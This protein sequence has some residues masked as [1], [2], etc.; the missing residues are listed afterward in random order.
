MSAEILRKAASL[1]RERARA[2]LAEDCRDL[3]MA[4]PDIDADNH[5]W[6]ICEQR[7]PDVDWDTTVANLPYDYDGTVAQH[8]A[9]W[10]PA[11]ALA[12]ADWL[13]AYA[14]R[15]DVLGHGIG[16]NVGQALAVARAYLGADA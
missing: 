11:V 9:P 14:E 6:H 5:G 13:D 1:M 7:Q 16:S 3:W 2:A 10:H 4:I 12:V 8:L 15:L